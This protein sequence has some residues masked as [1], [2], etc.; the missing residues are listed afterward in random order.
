[1]S[2]ER[3][4]IMKTKRILTTVLLVAIIQSYG[5]TQSD[6]SQNIESQRTKK[7][8]ESADKFFD[9]GEDIEFHKDKGIPLTPRPEPKKHKQ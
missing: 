3:M 5:C 7:Q 4:K 9:M 1:M 2:H 8:Q 6:D